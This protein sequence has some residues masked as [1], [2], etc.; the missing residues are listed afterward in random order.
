MKRN[1]IH[2]SKILIRCYPAADDKRADAVQPGSALLQRQDDPGCQV[3][4][5]YSHSLPRQF[6]PLVA[7]HLSHASA[8]A[9]PLNHAA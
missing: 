5:C 2:G 1:N 7:A 3:L 4:K 8:I 6:H 9:Q